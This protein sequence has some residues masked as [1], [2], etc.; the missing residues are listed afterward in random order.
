MIFLT[1][2]KVQIFLIFLSGSDYFF[3]NNAID[4]IEISAKSLENANINIFNIINN[5]IQQT[6]YIEIL[7]VIFGKN[8][9]KDLA[10]I[11][12]I[13]IRPENTAKK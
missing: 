13:V 7:N 1:F 11:E 10:G 4:I 9:I 5:F 6:E 3:N 2:I 8:Q 12:N